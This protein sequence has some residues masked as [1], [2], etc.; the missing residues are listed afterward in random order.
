M[1]GRV[2]SHSVL[3]IFHVFFTNILLMNYLI[4]ILS[5]SFGKMKE[6]GTFSFKVNLY[7]YCER[8]LT[9]FNDRAY[10]ELVL[11]PPPLSF[12]FIVLL[13]FSF[14]RQ[15]MT[16]LSKA[17]S[18]FMFW[19]ENIFYVLFFVVFE[20]L[21]SPLSYLKIWYNLAQI[22]RESLW[23]SERASSIGFWKSFAYC[24]L[25]FSLGPVIMLLILA[26]DLSN[27]LSIL[28]HHEGFIRT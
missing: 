4:A 7:Q 5:S 19:I 24:L 27:F 8:Y 23:L 20:L 3:T 1:P 10:G 25:W 6:S 28:T 11:N 16:R 26:I 18:Y 13:P 21:V 22:L 2:I 12:F 17:M 15:L 9:A 14:S